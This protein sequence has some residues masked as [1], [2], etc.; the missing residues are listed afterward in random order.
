VT[1]HTLVADRVLERPLAVDV[2]GACRMLGVSWDF[3][4]EH[5]APDVRIVRKGRRKLVPVA[6]LER[7]LDENA[8]AA[9]PSKR[10]AA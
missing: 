7:W 2:D 4:H 5:I 10:A 8:V 6:E 1:N 9:L 3:W